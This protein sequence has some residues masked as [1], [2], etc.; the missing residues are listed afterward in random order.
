MGAVGVADSDLGDFGH[1]KAVVPLDEAVDGPG[2]RHWRGQHKG[3]GVWGHCNGG[4][5]EG[6]HSTRACGRQCLEPPPCAG[7]GIQDGDP[8][9]PTIPGPGLSLRVFFV[10]DSP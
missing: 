7:A 3:L 8:K 1:F 5:G 6:E 4:G 10:Q 2:V 9:L